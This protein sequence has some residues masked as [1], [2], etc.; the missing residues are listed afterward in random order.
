MYGHNPADL[1]Y[2][3]QR[4]SP[5]MVSPHDPNI[6]YHASQY[7]HMTKDEGLTWETISP[8]LTAFEE[9]KQVISGSPITRDITGEEFYSTIYAIT[10]SPLKKGLIWTGAN[11]GPVFVTKNGGENWTNVSPADLKPGG[12]VQTVEASGHN[13]AKAFFAV[14][15]YLLDDWSPYIYKTEDYGANW[16]LIVNGIPENEPVRVIREDPRKEGLLYAGTESGVYVSFNDGETWDRFQYNL[17][18][19]PVT[20]IKIFRN[21]LILSTMGRSFWILN[22]ISPLRYFDRISDGGTNFL[23]QPGTTFR[24][25]SISSVPI[26]YYLAEDVDSL[27]L[28]IE[29]A[30]GEDIMKFKSEGIG[31]L[32][33]KKGFNRISWDMR[34]YGPRRG[35][36]RASRGPKVIPARYSVLLKINNVEYKTSIEVL[37]DPMLVQDGLVFS[38]YEEQ[39]NLSL[40]INKLISEAS[41]L[42]KSIENDIE[43]YIKKDESGKR[44][45]KKDK[46]NL[47]EL[48]SLKSMLVTNSGAYPQAKLNDQ[49]RYLSSMVSGAD[50]KPGNQAYIR[51]KELKDNLLTI[52]DTFKKLKH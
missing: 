31:I 29:D 28:R 35:R 2:R 26:S 30:R 27:E 19:V 48:K 12:R 40:D 34:T 23:F 24:S 38:D 36:G 44:L 14:Y 43:E 50:Q 1:K 41:S 8:D 46:Q 6:V 18:L 5:I 47:S 15:R 7:L 49:I 3:F 4:V 20:D 9:D 42:T 11:D 25:P 39:Y 37:P 13:P 10:E 21:D 45:T 22:D 51:F 52:Q 17:P 32:G 33:N 16:T